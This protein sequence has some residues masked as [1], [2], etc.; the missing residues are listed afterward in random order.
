MA[1]SSRSRR[2]LK[3]GLSTAAVG[4]LGGGYAHVKDTPWWSSLPP[5]RFGRAAIAVLLASADYKWSLRNLEYGTDEYRSTMKEVHQRSALRL[6][7][8]CSLNG[9]LFVK[10]GQHIASLDYLLPREYVSTFKVFHSSAPSTPLL[11]LKRVI[12][13]EFGVPAE[14]LFSEL[15]EQL[16]V[17]SLAQCHRG[18]LHDGRV[19]AVKIQH[20]DVR[21]NGYTDMSV[22]DL[23]VSGVSFVFPNFH[24]QWLAR[25]VRANLPNELDFQQEARNQEKFSA[26]FKH[27]TFIKAPRVYWRYTSTRVLT[28]EFCD[29]GKLDDLDYI[30]KHQLPVDEV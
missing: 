23:L 10:V 30:E 4:T 18:V 20:P 15:G 21:K 9:G 16:G 3:L 12:F 19:V 24:F 22:I 25:E 14:E 8:M 11:R 1:A 27:L 5:V 7:R 2:L 17:A 26:M 29:G 13:E 6:R 28:M